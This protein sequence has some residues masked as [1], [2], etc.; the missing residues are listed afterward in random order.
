MTTDTGRRVETILL[1]LRIAADMTKAGIMTEKELL[2]VTI[3]K[4]TELRE[5]AI[6]VADRI[7]REG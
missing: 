5:L 2:D 6:D 7:N 3:Q 4:R 1:P